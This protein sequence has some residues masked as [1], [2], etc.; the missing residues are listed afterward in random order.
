MCL[1]LTL[2]DPLLN[3]FLLIRSFLQVLLETIGPHVLLQLLLLLLESRSSARV[4][5]DVLRNELV[6]LWAM[7]KT[8]QVTV[9]SAEILLSKE[10]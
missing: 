3:Q 4:W 5:Q 2:Q 1:I 8:L 6:L 9:P 7:G 10:V